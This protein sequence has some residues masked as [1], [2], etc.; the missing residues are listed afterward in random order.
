MSG[1]TTNEGQA[2]VYRTFDWVVRAV[3]ARTGD[4]FLLLQG[5]VRRAQRQSRT[6]SITHVIMNATC[7]TGVI[8]HTT[9]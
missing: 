4:H 8:K 1:I 6:C 9:V 5:L 2:C 3:E 7:I